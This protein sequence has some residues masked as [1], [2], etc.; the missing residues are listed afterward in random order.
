M[1]RIYS[2]CSNWSTIHAEVIKLKNIMLKNNFP[3]KF[4]DRCIKLFFDKLFL[5]KTVVLT[6]PRKIVNISLPFMGKDSLK[7]R[8]D[9]SKIAKTY[10]PYC[11]I[12]VMFKSVNRLGSFF[13]FKDRV[14]LN[15]RSL[16]LYKFKCSRCNSAYAGKTKRH[17]LVRTFGN[18]FK[19]WY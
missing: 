8:N 3:A 12:Q 2:L 19:N 7:I 11:K 9:F 18:F 15:A 1:F 5:K 10:F 4:I 14:P 17:F 16:V 6:V 13:C